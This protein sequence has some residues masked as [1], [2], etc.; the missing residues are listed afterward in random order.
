MEGTERL[1]LVVLAML[2]VQILVEAL[3]LVVQL[4]VLATVLA[5]QMLV[6]VAMG[7]SRSIGM[8]TVP[9]LVLRA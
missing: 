5:G 4:L 1:V 8:P 2:L 9:R 7:L 3:V 6:L